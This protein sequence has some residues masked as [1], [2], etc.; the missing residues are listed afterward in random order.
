MYRWGYVGIFVFHK[1][2]LHL[3]LHISLGIG[4]VYYAFVSLIIYEIICPIIH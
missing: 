3:V 2:A 1:S 4:S